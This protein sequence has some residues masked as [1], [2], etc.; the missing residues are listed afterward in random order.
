MYKAI[1]KVEERKHTYTKIF[2]EVK[3]VTSNCKKTCSR[4]YDNR[5]YSLMDLYNAPSIIMQ[6]CGQNNVIKVT[7][8]GG[9]GDK[10]GYKNLRLGPTSIMGGNLT[11]R[12]E[13]FSIS[14][15]CTH[16]SYCPNN[17]CVDLQQMQI[18]AQQCNYLAQEFQL[19]VWWY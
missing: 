5:H 6:V 16:A 3:M 14:C 10:W 19:C 9:F 18:I 1:N 11:K 2:K 12:K 7:K 15:T 17:Y 13:T 4:S 8:S